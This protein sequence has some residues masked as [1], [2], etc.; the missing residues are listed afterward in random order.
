[1]KNVK[2]VV[3]KDGSIIRHGICQESTLA[4]QAKDGE[5]CEVFDEHKHSLKQ[6]E[7]IEIPAPKIKE[8]NLY[9][10]VPLLMESIVDESK[11]SELID[12]INKVLK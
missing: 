12:A 2:F 1:M 8:R 3:I 7:P 4:M 5:T 10:L 11:K 6:K 9:A